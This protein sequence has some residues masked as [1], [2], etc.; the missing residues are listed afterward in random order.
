MHT[1]QILA[2]TFSIDSLLSMHLVMAPV[3]W[4]CLERSTHLY[5]YFLL[6][7]LAIPTNIPFGKVLYLVVLGMASVVCVLVKI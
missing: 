3:I 5:V 7:S 2:N 1:N 6:I 4:L